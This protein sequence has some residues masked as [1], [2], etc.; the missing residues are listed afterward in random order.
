M[1]MMTDITANMTM[2]K[3]TDMTMDINLLFTFCSDIPP[4]DIYDMK[5]DKTFNLEN[6]SATMLH[7]LLSI[8]SNYCVL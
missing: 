8:A 4:Y 5:I 2:D 7:K 1:D 3:M 6:N